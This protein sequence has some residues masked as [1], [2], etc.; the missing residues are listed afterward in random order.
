MS[1][2]VNI[3]LDSFTEFKCEA[4]LDSI[5]KMKCDSVVF[6]RVTMIRTYQGILSG[7][8]LVIAESMVYKCV[9]CGALH[10]LNQ[11]KK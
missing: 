1:N 9:K 10:D 3:P 7:G 5:F 4:V 2:Q 8:R 11:P 6:D